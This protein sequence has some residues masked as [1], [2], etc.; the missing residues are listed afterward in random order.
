[1][2]DYTKRYTDGQ[3]FQDNPEWHSRESKWK[4]DNI[5]KILKKNRIDF[6]SVSELGCG[7]G[8]ILHNLYRQLPSQVT[9][10]GYDISPQAIELCST[11]END[12]LRFRQAD[13]LSSNID[14]TDLFLCIDILEHVEN[15]FQ[16]IRCIRELSDHQIFHFPI[17][18]SANALLR[19]QKILHSRDNVGHIH[20]FTKDTILALLKELDL[21]V[22]DHHYTNGAVVFPSGGLGN[23][24]ANFSRRMLYKINSDLAVSLL[25][26]YSL[27][28]LTRT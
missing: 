7:A 24:M 16:V 25:G 19:P 18:L 11:L 21:S 20:Y 13:I 14:R 27:L 2:T 3:Y 23:R 8:L 10:N 22:I 12:R 26:G 28:V 1:M 17:D 4:A 5:L 9:F 6:N 15:Y